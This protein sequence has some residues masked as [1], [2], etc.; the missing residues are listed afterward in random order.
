MRSRAAETAPLPQDQNER[1]LLPIM[2]PLDTDWVADAKL[3][4]KRRC[5]RNTMV[6]CRQ[7]TSLSAMRTIAAVQAAPLVMSWV[8]LKCATA[9][10]PPWE[11]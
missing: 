9:G 11:T 3:R 1:P 5:A 2:V 7:T 4:P 10:K 6:A 8:A